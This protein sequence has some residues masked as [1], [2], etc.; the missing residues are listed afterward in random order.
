MK[1]LSEIALILLGKGSIEPR[2]RAFLDG[3]LVGASA[4]CVFW[5]LYSALVSSAWFLLVALLNLLAMIG[6]AREV[7]RELRCPSWNLTKE[8]WEGK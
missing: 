1:L 7:E 8:S 4:V 5:S 2:Y 3:F 6:L